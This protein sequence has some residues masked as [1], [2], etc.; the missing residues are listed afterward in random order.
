MSRRA[1]WIV[2]TVLVV[3]LAGWWL[4]SGSTSSDDESHP[5]AHRTVDNSAYQAFRRALGHVPRSGAIPHANVGDGVTISGAVIDA[6][7]SKPVAGVEVVFLSPLGESSVTSGADGGY[8]IHVAA[9][10]YRAFVRDDSV[11]SVGRPDL[12]RLPGMPNADAAGMPDEGL[13]P[14]VVAND[15]VA[16]LDLSVL[17]GGQII[18]KV[19]DRSGNPIAG[20]VVR[21]RTN[22]WRPAL[23]SDIA[24]TDATGAYALRV[25][26]GVYNLE[27][28]HA[29]FAGVDA[30]DASR[31]VLAAGSHEQR[32]LVMTAG[33]VITGKVVA[34]DGTPASDG[35]IE[36]QWGT[37][38]LQFG[39]AGRIESDGRFRW[40]TTAPGDVVLR[41][42]PWK[43]PPSPSR[44]F[45]CTDG[46][47]FDVVF[48]LPDR[49]PDIEG[50]L[51]DATGAPVPFGHIDLAPLDGG[52]AQQERTDG[53]GRWA[54]LSMPDRKSVV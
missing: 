42:W 50:V 48:T 45:T 36:K 18:G 53:S 23:G 20:A 22:A 11:L 44:R 17:R 41:A 32:D 39:P 46:A 27:A 28:S 21:A 24:E 43:S 2:A 33:C 5:A 38:D 54:V 34:H 19:V 35:A 14:L 47:R 3:V 15:N 52:I 16:G 49:G 37:T 7:D 29:R 4:R 30:S 51:V 6:R 31:I 9:G 40:V 10:V 26:A 12:Q 1:F 8:S 13:M 25:P